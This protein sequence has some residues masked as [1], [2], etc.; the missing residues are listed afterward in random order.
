M[1]VHNVN[2]PIVVTGRHVD[3]TEAMREYARRVLPLQKEH[4]DNRPLSER[5]ADLQTYAASLPVYDNRSA[6]EIIGYDKNGI[7]PQ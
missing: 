3:V 1:Q 4:S 6:E 2:L 5:I 7:P